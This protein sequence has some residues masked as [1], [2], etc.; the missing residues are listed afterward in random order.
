MS[1]FKKVNLKQ[2]TVSQ[3]NK[4]PGDK[5]ACFMTAFYMYFVTVYRMTLT[6]V[7]YAE[8]CKAAKAIRD[9]FR[10]LDR[11]RMAIA[12][13]RPELKCH[14]TNEGIAEK[15]DELLDKGCPVPFSLNGDHYE[16]I[17]GRDIL[18]GVPVWTVDDPGGQGDTL[19]D[20]TT[21]EVFHVNAKGER[22]YSKNSKGGRRKITRVYYFL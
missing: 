1:E 5:A 7:E 13:G 12:A 6:W 22:V 19:A 14:D 11:T 18:N 3:F 2:K 9:D 4:Y 8:A 21:L 17:D 15:I 16:S 10:I 20:C